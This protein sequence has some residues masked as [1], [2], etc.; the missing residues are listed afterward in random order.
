[1]NRE[2]DDTFFFYYNEKNKYCSLSR[3]AISSAF[4]F[5]LDSSRFI[6][7][8]F[9]FLFLSLAFLV[10]LLLFRCFTSDEREN[11]E[12]ILIRQKLILICDQSKKKERMKNVS[13]DESNIEWPSLAKKTRRRR[14]KGKSQCFTSIINR[15]KTFPFPFRKRKTKTKRRLYDCLRRSVK[16]NDLWRK[17]GI[18]S[19]LTVKVYCLFLSDSGFWQSF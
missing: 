11:C 10:S 4:L 16:P 7:V 12:A 5:S 17:I 18:S 6:L 8:V 15:R 13:F 1:M 2:E 3:C 14:R 9:L 19:I